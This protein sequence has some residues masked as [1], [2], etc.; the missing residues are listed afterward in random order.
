MTPA[1]RNLIEDLFG[2]ISA[3]QIAARD[4]EADA[5]IGRL[6]R[7]TPDAA[8]AL[9]QSVLVQDQALREADQ[10]ISTLEE[11]RRSAGNAGGSFLGAADRRRWN[12]TGPSVQSASQ[13]PE[14]AYPQSAPTEAGSFM[15]GALQTAAGVAGGALLF[16]GV[17]SL[18][19]GATGG[20][21]GLGGL[22]GNPWGNPETVVN[23][24]TINEV[25]PDD[26]RDDRSGTRSADYSSGGDTDD[27][28]DADTADWNDDSSGFDDS[29]N[30]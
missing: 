10:R 3:H 22:A 14:P 28:D 15:R 21:G 30:T 16:E 11:E 12:P 6:M 4:P 18:F 7:D 23:E 19:H 29:T 8:Y 24:T 20:L 27:R 13:Q 17:R 5:L 2:R 1:E 25:V 26:D 9:V